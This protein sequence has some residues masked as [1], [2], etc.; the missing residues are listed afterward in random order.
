MRIVIKYFIKCAICYSLKKKTIENG[1]L[2]VSQTISK[3]AICTYIL[4]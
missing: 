4:F 3:T 1:V 2:L